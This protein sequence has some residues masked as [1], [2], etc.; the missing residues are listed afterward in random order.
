MACATPQF[1]DRRFNLFRPTIL[2]GSGCFFYPK[3]TIRGCPT[4]YG[5]LIQID[6]QDT[7]NFDETFVF[8]EGPA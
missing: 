7:G 5:W 3:H 2:F 8:V 4:E 1:P 6:S